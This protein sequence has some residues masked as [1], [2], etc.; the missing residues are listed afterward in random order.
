M[1]SLHCRFFVYLSSTTKQ[2]ASGE[3]SLRKLVADKEEEIKNLKSESQALKKQ[4][5]SLETQGKL[6]R[7]RSND[8]LSKP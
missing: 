5:S 4:L 6:K 3:G 1:R 8:D 7:D 2:Q